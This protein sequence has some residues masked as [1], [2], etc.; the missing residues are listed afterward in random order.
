MAMV[1]AGRASGGKVMSFPV[2]NNGPLAEIVGVFDEQNRPYF[3]AKEA[4]ET[5]KRLQ[6]FINRY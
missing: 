2:Y 3:D 1:N 5:V 4:P 6:E